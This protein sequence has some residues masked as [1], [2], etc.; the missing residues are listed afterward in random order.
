MNGFSDRIGL[1]VN[2]R[3]DFLTSKSESRRVSHDMTNRTY[4][5]HYSIL[6]GPKSPNDLVDCQIIIVNA[7]QRYD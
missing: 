5:A 1:E 3:M 7:R 4:Q 6:T 2:D